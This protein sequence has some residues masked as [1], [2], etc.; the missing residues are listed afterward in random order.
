MTE[1]DYSQKITKMQTDLLNTH[2]KHKWAIFSDHYVY[3]CNV[4]M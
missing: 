3:L 2:E 4:Y 1:E